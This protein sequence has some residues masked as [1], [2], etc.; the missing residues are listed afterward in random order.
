MPAQEPVASIISR[1]NRLRCSSR[2]ASRNRPASLSSLR[3]AVS[4]ARIS[5][6]AWFIVVRGVTW[7]ELA[8]TR[9]KLRSADFLPVSG[10]NSTMD[11][12][13]LPNRVTRQA[14]AS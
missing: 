14:A 7:W 10:S 2:W 1:S 4:S 12:T 6:M 3:R 5:L 9:M 13:S 8:K 11:S